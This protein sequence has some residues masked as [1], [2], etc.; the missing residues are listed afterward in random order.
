M[1]GDTGLSNGVSVDAADCR[2]SDCTTSRNSKAP[3]KENEGMLPIFGECVGE[4]ERLDRRVSGERFDVDNEIGG[5]YP[6]G[7]AGLDNARVR[8]EGLPKGSARRVGEAAIVN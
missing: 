4:T 5:M 1:Y 7:A 3:T 2:R 8:G 6:F